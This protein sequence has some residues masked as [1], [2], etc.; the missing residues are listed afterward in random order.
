ME[1]TLPA[2]TSIELIR[3][4]AEAITGRLNILL[5]NGL[6]GLVLVVLLLFL[7]LNARTAIWVAAGIP[8]SMLSAI[9]VMYV[10]GMSLNM[11]SLFAL[12]ITLGI[13]VDDAIVVG[14][15]ADFR[16]RTLGEK[17]VQAAETAAR[18]MLIP[19]TA[20]TITT[21]IAFAG[22]TFIGGRFGDMLGDIPLTV[23]AVLVASLVEC[24]FILPN[25]MAHA[26]AHSDKDHWYDMPSRVVN[27]GFERFSKTLFRPFIGFV[28]RA[29]YPVIAGAMLL[30][31]R[32]AMAL[33]Q[34]AGA[35]LGHWQLRHAPRCHPRRQH[36]DDARTP[37]RHRGSRER[38]RNK[39]RH[40]SAGFRSGRS[41][42]QF[43]Y[44]AARCR[45]ERRRSSG[46]H[47]H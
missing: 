7:F 19:V 34:F 16:S 11:I 35:R 38:I 27:R 9:A 33:L 25:H 41:G 32:C 45:Y 29:R 18:R 42:R 15:H 23:I 5:D 14:E 36:R 10:A 13:V 17:P 44:A 21:V 43:R 8:V 1:A 26:L 30:L 24:F 39:A 46:R 6:Q 40:Q 2:G 12:I 28:I 37:A 47:R 31:G 3:T 4:R 22:L 20:S